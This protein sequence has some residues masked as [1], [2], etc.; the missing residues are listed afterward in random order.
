MSQLE[1]GDLIAEASE[2][3]YK[4][5]DRFDVADIDFRFPDTGK[6]RH[7]AS[8]RLIDKLCALGKGKYELRIP[9]EPELPCVKNLKTGNEAKLNED[10]NQYD[11]WAIGGG[12]DS[13]S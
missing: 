7:T 3:T 13:S 10:R 5:G 4:E 2:V 12:H 8:N 6:T 1:W 11:A 9:P